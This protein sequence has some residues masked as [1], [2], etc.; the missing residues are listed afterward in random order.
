MYL[1]PRVCPE[2]EVEAGRSELNFR[3]I[4][5]LVLV[6]ATVTGIVEDFPP[7]S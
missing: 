2:D 5:I 1:I 6:T 4:V 3:L 7:T